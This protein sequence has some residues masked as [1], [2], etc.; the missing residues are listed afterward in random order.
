MGNWN[1]NKETILL[2]T[3]LVPCLSYL[4]RS[5]LLV[6]LKLP[7]LCPRQEATAQLFCST[8]LF[9]A[10]PYTASSRSQT[11]PHCSTPQ[12][13]EGFCF[14]FFWPLNS[15]PCRHI[16]SDDL[17]ISFYCSLLPHSS[18]LTSAFFCKLGLFVTEAFAA[19][20][21]FQAGAST[22]A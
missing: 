14:F 15:I 10:C 20:F 11:P 18:D 17:S 6:C 1:K 19:G 9:L 13:P 3:L 12:D 21:F 7:G 4:S 22:V 8:V 5:L 16:R 2:T